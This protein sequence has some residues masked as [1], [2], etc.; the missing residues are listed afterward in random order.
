MKGIRNSVT[1]RYSIL[2]VAYS[3]LAFWVYGNEHEMQTM[4][5]KTSTIK[6]EQ[7]T[8]DAKANISAKKTVPNVAAEV[9]TNSLES[10][11][12]KY[13]AREEAVDYHGKVE[14]QELVSVASNAWS[15]LSNE[16]TR[17]ITQPRGQERE[18][19]LRIIKDCWTA[20]KERRAL[21]PL[22]QYALQEELDIGTIFAVES[23]TG[24][25]FGL[26]AEM[27]PDQQRACKARLAD[28]WK[29]R[30]LEWE[31]EMALRDKIRLPDLDREM[32][33]IP[34]K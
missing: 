21:G 27:T 11:F 1:A 7:P 32:W 5:E 25:G 30:R 26:M 17:L 31:R 16:W 14:F 6:D 10:V 2:F 28:W 15:C 29:D 13:A 18:R 22:V 3:T 33:P 23:I 12:H 20:T 19:R 24:V 9:A 4:S 8:V 34:G